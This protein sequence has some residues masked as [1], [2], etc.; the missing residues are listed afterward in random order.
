MFDVAEEEMQNIQ[1]A[2]NDYD[3][4]K[5]ACVQYSPSSQ[6]HHTAAAALRAYA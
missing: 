6:I 2:Q 5:T 3:K 1:K 4:K